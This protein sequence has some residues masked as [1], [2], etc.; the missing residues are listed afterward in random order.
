[1]YWLRNFQGLIYT[2]SCSQW[3][4]IVG[5]EFSFPFLCLEP[6]NVF[7][8]VGTDGMTRMN[9]SILS[10]SPYFGS[11]IETEVELITTEDADASHHAAL[12]K[13]CILCMYS[14]FL[15]ALRNIY[16]HTLLKK[17]SP[18]CEP[19]CAVKNSCQ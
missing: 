7:G 5:G 9:A 19:L 15:L 4:H 13:S 16:I 2:Y 1:M 12:C 10:K 18:S 8:V 14:F 3:W 17:V 6:Q 11:H